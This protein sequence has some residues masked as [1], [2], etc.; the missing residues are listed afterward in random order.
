MLLI[1]HEVILKEYEGLGAHFMLRGTHSGSRRDKGY[2]LN[3]IVES[4]LDS[5]NEGHKVVTNS[6][7][8]ARN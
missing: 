5:E 6:E 8:D 4:E 7:V 2:G 1:C 3:G